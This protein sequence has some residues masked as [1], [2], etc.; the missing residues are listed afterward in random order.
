LILAPEAIGRN[1]DNL[2]DF[3]VEFADISLLQVRLYMGCWNKTLALAP[4]GRIL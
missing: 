4:T 2:D 3:P 1:F